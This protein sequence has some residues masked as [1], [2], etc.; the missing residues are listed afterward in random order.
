MVSPAL[1]ENMMAEMA[2]RPLA[3]TVAVR[4][5]FQAGE[6]GLEVAEVG[7]AAAGVV[8]AGG[9]AG[10]ERGRHVDRRDDC[11]GLA[12][13]VLA[14]MNGTSLKTCVGGNG[15]VV[16]HGVMSDMQN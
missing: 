10:F 2:L 9:I 16:F 12:A 3:K 5:V 1:R 8:K 11:A 15:R 6:R 4:R 13:V 7:V 14:H